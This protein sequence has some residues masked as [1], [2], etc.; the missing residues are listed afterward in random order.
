MLRRRRGL[1]P[2]P[3]GTCSATRSWFSASSRR[4]DYVADEFRIVLLHGS[5]C[6]NGCRTSAVYW[7]LGRI[8]HHLYLYAHRFDISMCALIPTLG[9]HHD[10][11]FASMDICL[12]DISL[13]VHLLPLGGQLPLGQLSLWL[14]PPSCTVNCVELVNDCLSKAT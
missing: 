10:R 9:A 3:T 13:H 1:P 4:S 2:E 7:C 12:P 5:T 6:T 8:I 11:T 14:L